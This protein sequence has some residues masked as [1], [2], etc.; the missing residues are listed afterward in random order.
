MMK[1]IAILS[2]VVIAL[3][4][5]FSFCK[6]HA[7]NKETQ[8]TVTDKGFAV[9]ELFTSEG[10]SSC[11]PADE[12]MIRLEKEFPEHV[13]FLG[14]HVDYW[15]HIGWKDQFDNP[16]YA[17]RQE[18]YAGQL[19]LESIY[20]PQVIINGEKEYVGSRETQIKSMIQEKLKGGASADIQLT[21]KKESGGSIEATYKTST[22]PSI[23]LNIALVQ[24]YA[25][26]N[27]TRGENN[28]HR[29]NHINIVREF[30][31]IPIDKTGE[32]KIDL[33]VPSGLTTIDLKLIAF[34]QNK[35][36]MKISGA[37]TAAIQ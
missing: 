29:L 1:A 3:T 11:P 30:R 26:T 18:S 2:F 32:G 5:S 23:M 4:L 12:A 13:C 37:T 7:T 34:T 36:D 6:S 33:P 14:Y 15:D 24:S 19:G 35:N 20:T 16:D 28:G 9:V 22:S 17:K 8:A 10:C 25:S 31:A 21:A 27:V